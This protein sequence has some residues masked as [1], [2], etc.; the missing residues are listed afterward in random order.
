MKNLQSKVKLVSDVVDAVLGSPIAGLVGKTI[1]QALFT[2]GEFTAD[3]RAQLDA[4]F[5][6]LVAREARLQAEI[7]GTA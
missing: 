6:D 7:D 2:R 1:A 5:D 3:E 4:H